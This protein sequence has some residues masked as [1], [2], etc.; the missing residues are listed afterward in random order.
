MQKRRDVGDQRKK[1]T[2][3]CVLLHIILPVFIAVILYGTGILVP[4]RNVTRTYA[5]YGQGIERVYQAPG[6]LQI[7]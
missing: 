2:W 3:K 4:Q 6:Q 5:Y 1:C 7:G